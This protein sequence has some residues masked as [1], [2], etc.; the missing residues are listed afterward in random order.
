[1]SKANTNAPCE[2]LIRNR[3]GSFRM[4]FHSVPAGL[5]FFPFPETQSKAK[6]SLASGVTG[7]VV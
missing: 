1:M 2:H 3:T 4:E 5:E 6:N 7:N